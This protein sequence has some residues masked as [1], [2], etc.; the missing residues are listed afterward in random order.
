MTITLVL[1]VLPTNLDKF[2]KEERKNVNRTTNEDE[3]NVTNIKK[4]LKRTC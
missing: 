2:S 3:T 4:K 1:F